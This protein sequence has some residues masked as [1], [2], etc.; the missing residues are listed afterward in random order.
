MSPTRRTT[1]LPVAFPNQPGTG[2]PSRVPEFSDVVFAGAV[3][4][5]TALSLCALLSKWG[6]IQGHGRGKEAEDAACELGRECPGPSIKCCPGHS[7]IAGDLRGGFTAFDEPESASNLAIGDPA[8]TTAEV[9]PG[10]PAFA[11]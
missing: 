10:F 11:D 4:A 6:R 8:R 7:K 1:G 2:G 5:V 9:F 3:V